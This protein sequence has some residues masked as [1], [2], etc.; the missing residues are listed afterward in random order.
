M[1]AR[2]AGG[3]FL[4]QSA[5][6]QSLSNSPIDTIGVQLYTLQ[7]AM[8]QDLAGTLA[9]VAKIGYKEVEFAGYF[10]HSPQQIKDILATHRLA[11][12]SALLGL[13]ELRDRLSEAIAAALTIGHTYL[14]CGSLNPQEHQSLSGYRA[15]ADLFNK[16]GAEC[17]KNGIQFGFH[18]HDYEFKAID[19]IIPYAILLKNT[20]PQLVK[21][22]LDTFWMSKAK[23]NPVK[24]LENYPDRFAL[25]HL[26]DMDGT[27]ARDFTEIGSGIINFKRILVSA[28]RA[29]VKHYFVEQDKCKISPF[30]S[31]RISLAYLRKLRL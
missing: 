11:A 15:T 6:V 17:A 31:I 26:K 27:P 10:N 21:M 18:N 28:E 16:I 7:D 30:E 24:Y 13:N 29:G 2:A 9:R 12:P 5:C 25:V 4:T 14:I 8:A 23:Q 22:E 3:L 20:D 19:G 1:G